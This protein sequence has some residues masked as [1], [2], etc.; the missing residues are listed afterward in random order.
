MNKAEGF[1]VNKI[2]YLDGIRLRN[3]IIASISHLEKHQ[4]YLNRI[5]VFPVPD[6]D[7]GTNMFLT[8]LHIS[9]ELVKLPDRAIAKVSSQVA[10]SAL[11][12][13]QGNS[14]AILA[15]FFHGFAQGAR[16]K[17]RLTTS[18]FATAVQNAKKAAYSALTDPKEGTILSVIS[19]WANYI[20]KTSQKTEDFVVLLKNSLQKAKK[21]LAETQQ[22]LEVLKK[23]GVVDAGALGFVH[24]LEGIVNFIDKGKIKR[25]I[26]LISH[27]ESAAPSVPLKKVNPGIEFRYC[28]ECIITGKSIHHLQL[29]TQLKDLGDSLIVAGGEERVRVHIHT[30]TPETVFDILAPHGEISSKK[31]DDMVQQHQEAFLASGTERIGIVTDSS[32]DLPQDFITHHHI[33]IIP[34][35]LTFG[36]QTFLD[37]VQITPAEFYD[38]LA[39]SKEHPTTSQPSAADARQIYRDVINRYERIL[40]IHLP[41]V[42]SGTLQSVENAAR[43]FEKDKIICIDGK[44]ISVA[45]GLVVMEAV[46]AIKEGLSL[47]KVIHRTHQAIENIRIFITLPTL[48]Y[49]VRGG[50]L[51][52][53]KGLIGKILHLNPIVSFDREGHV[54]L[55]AK[56]FGEKSA[57]KKALKMAAKEARQ[58]KEIKLIIAHANAY[59]KAETLA[60]E[61]ARRFNISGEIPILEAAPALGVHAGPGTVGFAFIG[62]N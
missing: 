52:K 44:G 42:S 16:G 35:K 13:A 55:A 34:V 49:L 45:L 6:G 5:N 28:T 2:R 1:Q 20:H 29:K 23:A 22:K 4:D 12:G 57:M 58:Y 59:S 62:Y 37:K 10:E 39:S 3:A 7:T 47:D 26:N 54:V 51:S 40:S 15:Q 8:M 27:Q 36:R 31:I 32:C 60:A 53:S 41:R 48:K 9:S 17:W 43:Q 14:G 46:A 30:N 21:S 56:A 11:M 18:A 24:L 33:H 50:R 19:D 61:L 25:I 38:K